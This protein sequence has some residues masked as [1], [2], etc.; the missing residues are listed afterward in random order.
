MSTAELI[1]DDRIEQWRC[2]ERP[3]FDAWCSTTADRQ[4][5]RVVEATDCPT[6][7]ATS[8]VGPVNGGELGETYCF[9]CGTHRT[10]PLEPVPGREIAMTTAA[11]LRNEYADDPDD[12][13]SRLLDGAKDADL[14]P[15]AL[16]LE[17]AKVIDDLRNGRGG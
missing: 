7:K 2:D 12:I 5:P 15:A 3:R 10:P 16:L 1:S 4:A 11:E 8:C 17:A 13:V 9:W 6:C 14:A